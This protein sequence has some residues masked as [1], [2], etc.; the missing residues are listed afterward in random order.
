MDS[1]ST[2][3]IESDSDIS[4]NIN[5]ESP[6]YI[7]KNGLFTRSLLNIDINKERE[8]LVKYI[9]CVYKK[10]DTLNKFQS[11]N[12]VKHYRNKHPNIVYNKE[13]EKSL[14]LKTDIP[15]KNTLFKQLESRKR[16]RTNT[17]IDFN[18]SE[19]YNKILNFIIQNNL[20][21]NILNSNS[22]KD[23]LNYYNR[24]NPIINRKK[25]KIILE[26][27]YFEYLS[28]FNQ[29]I[30]QN[31]Y[32]KVFINDIRCVVHIINIIVQNIL[33]DYISNSKSN[34]NIIEYTDEY[35]DNE[36]NTRSI[37]YNIKYK[38]I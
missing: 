12:F 13:S 32:N 33:C 8:I 18:E 10:V 7:F 25:F 5:T 29:Q 4:T 37:I 14:K 11:S 17:L 35:I 2:S 26:K 3:N 38:I 1:I 23:L 28:I 31:I 15:D 34:Q 27:T 9:S 24:L 30:Q 21:F 22:F 20:S 16:N 36:E 6:I 19:A